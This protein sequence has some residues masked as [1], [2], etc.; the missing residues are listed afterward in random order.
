[1]NSLEVNY[2]LG[3]EVAAKMALVGF[4]TP[5]L[6]PKTPNKRQPLKDKF[7]IWKKIFSSADQINLY[8]IEIIVNI[9]RGI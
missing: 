2:K 9:R 3:R 8:F 4:A 6:N 1:M 5:V 7:R